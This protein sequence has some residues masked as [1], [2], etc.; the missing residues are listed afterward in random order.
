MNRRVTCE[1]YGGGG[2]GS[3]EEKEG[4]KEARS[5]DNATPGLLEQPVIILIA[6][7]IT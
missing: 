1:G 6:S 4:E 7:T 2:G 5:A 3:E